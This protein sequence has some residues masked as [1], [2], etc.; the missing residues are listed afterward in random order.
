MSRNDSSTVV[1]L[2]IDDGTG[3]LEVVHYL[4]EADN[5]LVREGLCD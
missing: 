4:E 1:K 3:S 2:K 5:E